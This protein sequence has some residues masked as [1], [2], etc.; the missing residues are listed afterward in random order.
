VMEKIGMTYDN[1]GDFE[2]PSVP[3]G[4]KLKLHVLY[5][6]RNPLL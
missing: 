4:H 3:D 1:R 2:H 6:I 5:R